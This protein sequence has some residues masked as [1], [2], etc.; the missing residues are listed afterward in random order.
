M[1]IG[2]SLAANLAGGALKAYG[3][4]KQAKAND[5]A[6]SEAQ[7]AQDQYNSEMDAWNQGQAN[8]A[9]GAAM[10][11]YNERRARELALLKDQGAS[12]EELFQHDKAMRDEQMA[13]A[14][15]FD[16]GNYQEGVAENQ[17]AAQAEGQGA[18]DESRAT[19]EGPNMEGRSTAFREAATAAMAR[20][21]AA[22]D[23][24]NAGMSKLTGRTRERGGETSASR[25]MGTKAAAGNLEKEHLGKMADM[26]QR[27]LGYTPERAPSG[28]ADLSGRPQEPE[29]E[30]QTSSSGNK[31]SALG[32]AVGA[33]GGWLGGSSRV[34]GD[35]VSN[36]AWLSGKL[37]GLFG[38]KKIG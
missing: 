38:G 3:G 14:Q 29:M 7:A 25:R 24:R 21:D 13:E 10:A 17:G 12:Q 1:S 19:R 6:M 28:P 37:G 31:L 9:H 32:S 16:Y 27:R 22:G 36:S 11:A 5:R 34:G 2:L 18:L 26:R 4:K 20:A 35:T 23:T 8:A 15:N 33:A 30:I